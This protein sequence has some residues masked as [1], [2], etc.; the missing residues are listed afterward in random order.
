MN[1][2]KP[3]KEVNIVRFFD[4]P[5]ELVFNAWTTAGHLK[6]WYAPGSCSV[7]IYKL[8]FK[9]GGVFQHEIKNSKGEGCMCKGEYLEII[10]NKKI[11]YTL[12]FCDNDGNSITASNV[13]KDWPDETTVTVTFEDYNGKTKLTLHQTV[14]EE[15]AK[16]T[17][18]YPS[19]LE[20]LDR[21]EKE[22]LKFTET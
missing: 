9:P 4:A 21:L 7:T 20:M 3:D 13:E 18:A 11:V 14:S 12:G 2:E 16:K 10:E 5:R 8:E 6:N 19:W 17:G 22:S 15:L 1:S